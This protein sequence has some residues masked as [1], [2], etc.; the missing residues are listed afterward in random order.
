M[1]WKR[2]WRPTS[3]VWRSELFM[4]NSILLIHRRIRLLLKASISLT[5][6][7]DA[8]APVVSRW[9]LDS[10]WRRWPQVMSRR[11]FFGSCIQ[12]QHRVRQ[13]QMELEDSNCWDTMAWSHSQA[14]ELFGKTTLCREQEPMP[15]A[16]TPLNYT[17][18]IY[19]RCPM[20]SI[21]KNEFSVFLSV[22]LKD[23]PISDWSR[24]RNAL[25]QSWSL[26]CDVPE[27]PPAGNPTDMLG[28]NLDQTLLL[29]WKVYGA[30]SCLC[31]V[32][33]SLGP[34]WGRLGS[35]RGGE[36]EGSYH[37]FLYNFHTKLND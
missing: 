16:R 6:T 17:W 4:G 22:F 27:M 5:S 34:R 12:E 37:C 7:N 30:K 19:P 10:N 20:G 28:V 9:M 21:N 36:L 31:H 33:D 18:H 8:Q 13:Q 23:F 15:N 3:D 11:C 2:N 32:N 25:S 26:I 14:A 1:C 35:T 24:R 29:V